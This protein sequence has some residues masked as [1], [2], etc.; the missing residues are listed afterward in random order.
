M[1]AWLSSRGTEFG[2]TLLALSVAACSSAPVGTERQANTAAPAAAA[3]AEEPAASDAGA[4]PDVQASSDD[5]A[6][7]SPDAGWPDCA[8]QPANVPTRTIAEIWEANA[9][10]PEAAWLDGVF[11]TGVSRGGCVAG[12]ACH[13][14]VQAEQSFA[15]L[16]DGAHKAI[17][18]F[19]SA[20][21]AQH[22]AGV[23]VGDSV[24]VMGWGLRY[25]A[26][27]QNELLVQVSSAL[28]G[29]FQKVGTGVVTPIPVAL[30]DLTLDNY[31]TYGPLLVKATKLSGKASAAP[32]E[33]FGL[34]PTSFSGTFPDGGTDIVSLSPFFLPGG[35]F[36]ADVVSASKVN[37]FESITGVFGVFSPSPAKTYLELCPR[38]P[39]D[40]V[41]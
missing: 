20:K 8:S 15:S 34:Y 29:C 21:A 3:A 33:T 12:Q 27:G 1:A 38:A 40:L 32:D 22:F 37:A 36:S 25:T 23:S 14:Y 19:V 41:K 26:G 16:A 31:E 10:T 11:V 7:A 9:K 30:G 35:A 6:V 18:V 17:K 4:L 39:S 13:F 2:A 24:N 28:P 5:A